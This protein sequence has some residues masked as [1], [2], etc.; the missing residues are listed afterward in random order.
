MAG[1]Q[2]RMD[3]RRAVQFHLARSPLLYRAAL[4]L[5]RSRNWEKR[6]YLHLIRRGDAVIEAGA[7]VGAFT[8]LFSDLVGQHGSVQAFEPVGSS[9]EM[10]QMRMATQAGFRNYFLS[11][12][13]LSERSGEVKISFPEADPAQ[14]SLRVQRTGSWQTSTNIR[15]QI[16]SQLELDAYAAGFSRLDFLKC[17]VEG[18]E[19]LVFQGAQQTLRRWVPKILVELNPDWSQSFGY[20]PADTLAFLRSCG[21][22]CFWLIGETWMPLNA[23]CLATGNV[24]CAP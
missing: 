23:D 1:L 6:C 9:F 15:S 11:R 4:D 22:R 2:F 18:A 5:L 14:A 12:Q 16:V 10:L 7:N 3:S 19:L 21:Y 13:A 8:L 20:S 17:D 24:L